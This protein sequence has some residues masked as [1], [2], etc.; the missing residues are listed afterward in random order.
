MT[1]TN[2]RAAGQ[3]PTCAQNLD[4]ATAM[5]SFTTGDGCDC[6]G[7]TVWITPVN[8][9]G[10]LFPIGVEMIEPILLAI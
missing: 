2:D 9:G 5:M 1:E 4:L 6:S 8:C 7:L 10:G 3:Q